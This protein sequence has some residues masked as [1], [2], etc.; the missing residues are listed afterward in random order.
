M[1]FASHVAS[2]KMYFPQYSTD[3]YFAPCIFNLD[4]YSAS[5]LT[6]GL[7][8]QPNQNAAMLAF[9]DSQRDFPAI[10]G[11]ILVDKQR[12]LAWSQLKKWTREIKSK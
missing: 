4:G 9:P 10:F 12:R 8:A 2:M 6:F 3:D 11:Y 5:F 7:L 1:S